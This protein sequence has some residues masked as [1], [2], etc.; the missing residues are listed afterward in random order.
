MTKKKP[1]KAEA[2]AKAKKDALKKATRRKT[3]EVERALTKGSKDPAVRAALK[4]ALS[5]APTTKAKAKPTTKRFSEVRDQLAVPA[6]ETEPG[7]F[8][9]NLVQPDGTERE[10]TTAEAADEA[11]A[12]AGADLDERQP[13]YLCETNPPSAATPMVRRGDGYCF[14]C[15]KFICDK[16]QGNTPVGP[17]DPGAHEDEENEEELPEEAFE[18]DG[19]EAESTED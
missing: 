16:H 10:P 2:S 7:K 19:E 4:K 18:A 8:A 12:V 13:C 14:G 6:R 5:K 11:V 17:H 3:V 15:G 1:T 9:A